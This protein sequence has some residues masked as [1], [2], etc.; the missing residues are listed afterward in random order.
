[1]KATDKDEK[2]RKELETAIEFISDGDFRDLKKMMDE[3]VTQHGSW[4]KYW[5]V[6]LVVMMVK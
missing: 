3:N 5:A 4:G 1:M 6:Q 2:V